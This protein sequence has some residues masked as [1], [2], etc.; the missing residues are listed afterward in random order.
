M[1][2]FFCGSSHRRLVV[3]GELDGGVVGLR[4]RALEQHLRH[5]HRRDLDEL[6]GEVDARLVR[7]MPVGVV[8]AELAQLVVGDLRNPLAGGEAERSAPQARDRLDVAL[9]RIVIDD[10]RPRRDR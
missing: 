4:A 8:V 9:A 6:L 10:R 5:R 7:A 1:I 3:P 2:L